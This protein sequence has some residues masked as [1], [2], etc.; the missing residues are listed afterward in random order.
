MKPFLLVSTRPEEEALVSEYQ[1]Y[2]RSTGLSEDQLQLAEFDLLGLPPVEFEDYAGILVAGSP[3]GDTTLG[4][5]KSKTQQWVA[6]E[7]REFFEGA[8]AAQLPLLATGTAMTIL[9]TA[10]GGRVDSDHQ[11]LSEVMRVTL[12][13][14]GRDEPIT[15]GLG[16][17]F[18][19][20]ITHTESVAHLPEGAVRLAWSANCPVQMFRSG[21]RTFAVQFSPELDA[22]AIAEKL[23]AYA[24]AG[25]F[26][27]G[28]LD[29]LVSTGRHE[30]GSQKSAIILKNFVEMFS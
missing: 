18:L 28:D 13:R 27:I 9:A 20:Y 14:E 2:L 3:Y 5:Q 10:L 23:E 26:G 29:M 6:E 30:T 25:D 24:D 4:S 1:A 19:A 21:D 22:E 17:D 12:T 16:E 15:K 8:L 7:L 11:E